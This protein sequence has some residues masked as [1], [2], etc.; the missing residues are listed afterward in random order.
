M[1]F[2]SAWFLHTRSFTLPQLKKDQDG[3]YINRQSADSEDYDPYDKAHWLTMFKTPV[4]ASTT[5]QWSKRESKQAWRLT[6]KG[7]I[8]RKEN[9]SS[10]QDFRV[11]VDALSSG[12]ATPLGELE[13]GYGGNS[14]PASGAST[15]KSKKE[16]RDHYKSLQGRKSK[17][18]GNLGGTQRGVKDIGGAGEDR[19]SAPW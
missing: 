16:M 13:T 4:P 1:S 3:N 11:D 19:F 15:P 7:L 14:R 6:F 12:L 8:T 5:P 2:V 9:P 10:V 18:K 17:G